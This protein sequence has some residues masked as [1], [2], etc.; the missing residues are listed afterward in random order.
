MRARRLLLVPPLLLSL[1]LPVALARVLGD[2]PRAPEIAMKGL[3]NVTPDET[4]EVFRD[5]IALGSGCRGRFDMD[6]DVTLERMTVPG[7]RDIHRVQLRFA[8]FRLSTAE[9]EPDEPLNF[10]RECAVRIQLGPPPGKRIQRVTARTGVA[11]TKS[12]G[13]KLILLGNL[14]LG[15]VTI[16]RKLLVY[17]PGT[18]HGAKEDSFD[19]ASGSKPEEVLPPLSCGEGK[20]VGFDYTWI[21][22]RKAATDEVSVELSGDQVLELDAELS[23]CSAEKL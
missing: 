3:A 14:E 12:K 18:E 13:A 23:D 20:I 10:A 15:A 4:Q 21:A 6:G 11:S 9:R 7:A 1:A 17:E 5:W 22:E 2:R 19:L 8:R 16:G